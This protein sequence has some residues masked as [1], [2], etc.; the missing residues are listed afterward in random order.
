MRW[1]AQVRC[2]FP[3]PTVDDTRTAE[4]NAS[5]EAH[6]RNQEILRGDEKPAAT[7]AGM[8]WGGAG[9]TQTSRERNAETIPESAQ[10]SMGIAPS[11]ASGT[12]PKPTTLGRPLQPDKNHN[13]AWNM[14]QIG[15]YRIGG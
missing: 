8:S 3:V 10:Q 14:E 11:V 12:S 2:Q 4:E 13:E 15:N 9:G 1:D 7:D 6:E 5:A